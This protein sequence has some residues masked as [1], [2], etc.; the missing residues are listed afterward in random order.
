MHVRTSSHTHQHRGHTTVIT[1]VK[2]IIHY[3]RISFDDQQLV[4]F[5]RILG[6]CQWKS[7]YQMWYQIT[8]GESKDS[9]IRDFLIKQVE[10]ILTSLMWTVRTLSVFRRE[11][12]ANPRV[13]LPVLLR[14]RVHR[15][16]CLNIPVCCSR[17]FSPIA[18]LYKDD[19][20]NQYPVAQGSLKLASLTISWTVQYTASIY[21]IGFVW[22]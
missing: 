16:V 6:I 15:T 7:E 8:F 10:S 5:F 1:S 2:D 21:R 3:G 9:L 18:V 17:V 11:R 22:D 14:I 12:A 4:F 19:N 20:E 13:S